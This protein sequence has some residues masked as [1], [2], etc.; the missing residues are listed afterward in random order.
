M[1]ILPFCICA[2]GERPPKPRALEVAGGLA[3][4][5]RTAAFAE[6]QAIHAFRWAS[7]YFQDVPDELRASWLQLIPEEEKH[8]RLIVERMAELGFELDER[9][10][11]LGLWDSLEACTT[12]RELCLRIAA[13]EERGRRAGVLLSRYLAKSDPA[14]AAVFQEIVE[15][16]VAHVALA[17]TY[18]GW[19]P[20]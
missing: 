17:E 15:D 7:E 1:N 12:G 20:E 13:S 9:P 8:Y 14:T 16:E 5:M 11:S 18:F 6:K 4:R 3:D 10:V 19:K 2:E